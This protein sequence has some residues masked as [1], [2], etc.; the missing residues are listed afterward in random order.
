VGEEK[1]ELFLMAMNAF[2]LIMEIHK[3]RDYRACATSAMRE[4][5]NGN[6]IIKEVKKRT[7]LE[8]EIISGDEESRLITKSVMKNLPDEGNFM[9]IDVGG[10]STELTL[11][12][13]G[14]IADSTS[15]PV[16]A[17][18]LLDGMVDKKTWSDME[19][20]I[21][22]VTKKVKHIRA[23]GTGGNISKLYRM[24]ESHHKDAYM[25]LDVL[26]DLHEKISK[27]DMAER[28]YQLQLNPDRA[29]VIEPAARIYIQVMKWAKI[30]EI[31]APQAGLKEGLIMDLWENL[32]EI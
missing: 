3:V 29:D 32:I 1:R 15:F 22:E 19:D 13:D 6:E 14:H 16:G 11:I 21:A 12:K 2:K 20:W 31:I 24:S 10:G 7:G 8:L 25:S 26:K 23:I 18:R 5:A 27:L 4:A 28:I 30:K 17:V 9:N